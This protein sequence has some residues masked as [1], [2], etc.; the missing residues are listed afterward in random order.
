MAQE[1]AGW[2]PALKISAWTSSTTVHS[3]FKHWYC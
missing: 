3:H 1:L 2:S